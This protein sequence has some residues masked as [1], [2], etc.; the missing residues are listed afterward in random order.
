MDAEPVLRPTAGGGTSPTWIIH[1]GGFDPARRR[2]LPLLAGIVLAALGM[3]LVMLRT[4]SLWVDEFAT[5]GFA[6]LTWGDL[7]GPVAFLEPNPPTYYA[8]IKLWLGLVGGRV[9]EVVL[10]IPSAF[11]AAA[12]LVPFFLFCRSAFGPRAALWS[13]LLLA[14]SA[15]HLHYAQEARVYPLVFFA[16]A[17]GLL[18]VQHLV[19]GTGW[20]RWRL[21]L[22][23][24]AVTASLAWLHSTGPLVAASLY[25]YAA[26]VLAAQRR[27]S[28]SAL[29]P[30]ALA[31]CFG[32]FLAGPWLLVAFTIARR[33]DSAVAWI[34]PPSLGEAVNV[35]S[36]IVFA[37]F[38]HRLAVPCI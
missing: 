16:F 6:S 25:V 27:A 33:R 29:M 7:F 13:T 23:L 8:I 24:G 38:M 21:A 19:A 14:V 15:Q 37:P 11:V 31:G 36:G 20:R 34:H 17:C 26:A 28:W 22:V 4:Q 2:G 1:G 35:V 12:S 32:L 5:L 10:R 18:V 30:L 9:S 3:R